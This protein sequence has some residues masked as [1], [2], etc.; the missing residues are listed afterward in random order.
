M[1]TVH[2]SSPADPAN[3]PDGWRWMDHRR[4]PVR[5]Q[6]PTEP[7]PKP[8]RERSRSGS[9]SRNHS[10]LGVAPTDPARESSHES[11]GPAWCNLPVVSPA[12]LTA[13]G[14]V[15]R[16]FS[17]RRSGTPRLDVQGRDVRQAGWC[18]TERRLGEFAVA[19]GMD[20]PDRSRDCRCGPRRSG[21]G[22]RSATSPTR[23]AGRAESPRSR[24][25]GSRRARTDAGREASSRRRSSPPRSGR[26]AARSKGTLPPKRARATGGR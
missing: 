9:K 4:D 5:P 8:R 15:S 18:I 25:P 23:E 16:P 10:A 6:W 20:R 14:T 17:S 26:R 13:S 2:P 11:G 1:T 3:P 22:A 7:R 21:A 24:R 19:I 12:Y